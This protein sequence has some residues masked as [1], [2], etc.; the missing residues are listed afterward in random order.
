MKSVTTEEKERVAE[1]RS[2]WGSH[3]EQA[4]TEVGKVCLEYGGVTLQ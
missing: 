1:F 4:K 2:F 3:G